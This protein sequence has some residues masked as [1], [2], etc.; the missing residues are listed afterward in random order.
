MGTTTHYG[1][2]YPNVGDSYYPATIANTI[3][4][5]DT[6]LY[7]TNTTVSTHT[8]QIGTLNSQMTTT[9]AVTDAIT[10]NV[11]DA[12]VFRDSGGTIREKHYTATT[13]TPGSGQ[14]LTTTFADLAG[15]SVTFTPSAGSNG[16]V[17]S[18]NFFAKVTNASSAF[19]Y[20]KLLKD[21]ALVTNTSA[22]KSL[23]YYQDV[24]QLNFKIASWSGAATIKMQVRHGTDTNAITCHYTLYA[25][26]QAESIPYNATLIVSEL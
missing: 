9:K 7:N 15:S 22:A 12:F 19:M 13:Y 2:G 24:C 1:W 11:T 16:V 25:N 26:G 10:A 18:Y 3:I 21:G 23:P 8:S 14:A 17:Y 4:A 5:I 6:A 20:Y